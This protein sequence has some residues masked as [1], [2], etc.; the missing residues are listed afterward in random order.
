MTAQALVAAIVAKGD[1][2]RQ[3]KS[4]K[5]DFQAQLAEL[6]KLKDEYKS[7]TGEE[8]KPPAAP[9]AAK[10]APE[11]AK[12]DGEKSKSQLKKEKKLAEKAAASSAPKEK[13][14]SKKP[15]KPSATA[16][17]VDATAAIP[18]GVDLVMRQ[19]KYAH[20]TALHG[21][22]SG[23][24]VTPWEVE[25]E[26][27]VDYEKL[28]DT[29]G[30]SKLTQDL[31]DR[32][33][34]LTGVRAHR[35]L[36]RGYFFAHRE[37][38][39]ILDLYEKGQKFYLYTGRGPS[40]GSLHLGH[41]IPFSFT[42]WLQKAFNVPL[43]IQL[44]D[45]EKF[46]FKDQTLD[47]SEKMAWE[48]SKDI[49]AC[50]FDP[51]KTFI[52]RNADYIDTMYPE[53]L[54][55]QKCVTYNQ[56]RGIF[57]FSGSDNIGKSAFP[58]V[59]ACPSFPQTFPIPFSGRTDLRCLIPC[60]IDQDPYFRMTRDVAP[61]IGYQKP[62][63]IFSK[64]F[65]ALQ[66]ASTKMSGSNASATIYISDSADVVADKIRR[67]AFSGGGETKADH[68]KYGANLDVDIPFQYLTFMLEDDAELAQLAEEYGSGR[69]MSGV[70]K[71][72]LIQVMA[73]TNAAFQAK[74]AAITDDQIREFMRV[75]PLEF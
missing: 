74:R 56:V 3:L 55:I 66:G 19:A 70:V 35:Y 53:I 43:V 60:A 9:K 29:F 17:P 52:F 49:I 58:A 44:T 13:A 32:V 71:D 73:D 4:D 7:A 65:P 69:M 46:L 42:A 63:L 8:Y 15:A 31:V 33:E 75:R 67:F 62:T 50:G 30:C 26:G 47:E 6:K 18:S 20:H 10:A 36:R 54:K 12:A 34:K 37:F 48:N 22:S 5:K 11:P 51:K 2:I 23:Q 1:E 38:N 24:K 28:V 25:A 57:G 39:E 27:G 14:A 16:K 61:R 68:E 21:A 72:R 41:L 64:F 59:Q 45:D 40:S